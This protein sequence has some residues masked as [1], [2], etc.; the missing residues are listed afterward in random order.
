MRVIASVNG[1]FKVVHDVLESCL[2]TG[3]LY[4][5]LIHPLNILV[6]NSN[7]PVDTIAGLDIKLRYYGNKNSAGIPIFEYR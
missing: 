5:R 1:W 2:T 4:I 7:A 3:V 6:T